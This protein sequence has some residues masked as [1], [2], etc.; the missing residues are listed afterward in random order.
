MAPPS[1]PHSKRMLLDFEPI[2]SEIQA[3]RDCCDNQF[4][5]VKARLE[6][7]DTIL[8]TILEQNDSI[9]KM[10]SQ[11]LDFYNNKDTKE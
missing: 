4:T 8:K 2:Y 10:Q 1:R 3:L 11:I 6:K 5:E 9:L 7:H